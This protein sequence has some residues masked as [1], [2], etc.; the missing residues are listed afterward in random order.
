MPFVK[1]EKDQKRVN[2]MGFFLEVLEVSLDG[3]FVLRSSDV[4]WDYD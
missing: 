4:V 1:A 2:F 3:I